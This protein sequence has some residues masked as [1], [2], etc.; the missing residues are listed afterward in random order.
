MK[1]KLIFLCYILFQTTH[2]KSQDTINVYKTFDDFKNNNG[3]K[4]NEYMGISGIA[5]SVSFK[6]GNEI[7]KLKCKNFWGFDYNGRLYR[8][9]MNTGLPCCVFKT[10][11]CI[12]Y[13]N[14][15]AHLAMEKEKTN[16]SIF[17]VGY[18]YYISNN[19]NSDICP[20]QVVTKDYVKPEYTRAKKMFRK[21]KKANPQHKNFYDCLNDRVFIY[22]VEKCIEQ[23]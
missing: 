13:A 16:S 7:V 23:Y 18:Y 4:M 3:E 17:N 1:L 20:M 2:I 9:D 12:F 11:K 14:G 8:N 6:K 22:F 10:G 21:F 15:Q 5:V 19:L